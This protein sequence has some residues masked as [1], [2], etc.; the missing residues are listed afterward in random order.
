VPQRSFVARLLLPVPSSLAV[1]LVSVSPSGRAWAQAP[2][3][4]PVFP[5]SVELITVDA[6]VLD[7][8]GQPVPGLTK[9][10][11]V[12][13]EDGQPRD[14]ASFEAFDVGAARDEPEAVAPGVVA[15]NEPAASGS[16]R[17]FAVVVDDLGIAPERT[18]A[19]QETVK[20]LLERSVRD[21]DL[22]TLGTTS[23]NAWWSAR[24]PEGQEDLLAVLARARGRLVDASVLE[25]MSGY[26]AFW[27][28]NREDSMSTAGALTARV[29][30]RWEGTGACPVIPGRGSIGCDGK[31]RGRAT[32]VNSIRRERLRYTLAC[33]R[34]AIEALAPVRGRKSLL[35]LSEGFLDDFGGDA[36][37]VAALSRE[38]NTA[39]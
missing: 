31:V 33:V 6:V 36:R 14:V 18:A 29:V 13:K 32:Q 21:G 22:V 19:A 17:A 35:L 15:S 28:A 30:A 2:S 38:A 3:G 25:P 24:V 10:D 34:R 27:I 7:K 1:A 26:E 5:S 23:G 8:E 39:V 9:D 16:G 11:F 4:P 12:V 20:A 37:A